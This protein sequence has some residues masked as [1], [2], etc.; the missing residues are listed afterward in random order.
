MKYNIHYHLICENNENILKYAI[1]YWKLY[2]SHVFIYLFKTENDN[3]EKIL[4]KYKDFITV[5]TINYDVE[6]YD[7]TIEQKLINYSYKGS[8]G[9]CDFCF[10]GKVTDI[11]YFKNIENTLNLMHNNKCTIY[12]PNKF[13]I[14]SVPS[15]MKSEYIHENTF[16]VFFN[17]LSNMSFFINPNEISEL[18]YDYIS[19]NID[20][21]GNIKFFR[22]YKSCIL[23]VKYM[24]FNDYLKFIQEKATKMTPKQK[25]QN[26]NTDYNKT[27]EELNNI[28]EQ[29]QNNLQIF[30]LIL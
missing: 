12:I 25:K 20:P 23:D 10:V 22:G 11:L 30:N 1:P 13:E 26:S 7:G 24:L 6:K 27:A 4:E 17:E 9:K 3:S 2:A 14:L 16:D 19:G 5:F 8:K 15:Y 18:N 21:I 29:K 28:Y